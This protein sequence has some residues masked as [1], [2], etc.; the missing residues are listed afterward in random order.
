MNIKHLKLYKKRE[1]DAKEN[2][3]SKEE[4]IE[5]YQS[6]QNRAGNEKNQEKM[7]HMLQTR[8]WSPELGRKVKAYS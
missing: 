5:P 1:I 8:V 3:Q 2:D 7:G 4:N 6:E